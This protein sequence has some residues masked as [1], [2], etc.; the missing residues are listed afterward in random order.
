LSG[1]ALI[2]VDLDGTNAAEGDKWDLGMGIR[3]VAQA[4][5]GTL[6]CSRMRVENFV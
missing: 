2:H 4:P 6:C 3:E 1:Q 5:D